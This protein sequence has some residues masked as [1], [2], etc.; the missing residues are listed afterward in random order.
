MAFLPRFLADVAVAVI[1]AWRIHYLLADGPP[2]ES[3][4]SLAGLDVVMPARGLGP[5]HNTQI[6]AL[7]HLLLPLGGLLPLFVAVGNITLHFGKCISFVSDDDRFFNAGHAWMGLL[8]E[9]L[10]RVLIRWGGEGGVM[11]KLWTGLILVTLCNILMAILKLNIYIK[12]IIGYVC[13][14]V[15]P[16]LVI[17]QLCMFSF[18]KNHE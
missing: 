2:E 16:F 8:L 6:L 7:V 18:V 4:A 17:T 11:E 14:C 9:G 5:A 12:I 1:F 10:L 15:P 13:V 3:L